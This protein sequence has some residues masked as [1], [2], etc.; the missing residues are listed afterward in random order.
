MKNPLF[1][2]RSSEILLIVLSFAWANFGDAQDVKKSLVI[3]I[4]GLGYGETGFSVAD[5]PVLDRLMNG[6]WHPDYNGAFTD[7]A[8]AGGVLGTPT[9][10]ITVSGPGWSTMTTGVWR[11]RHQVN[12]NGGNF[13]AGNF[14]DNPPYLATV[15]SQFPQLVTASFVNWGPIDS[16]IMGAVDSDADPTNNLNFRGDYA[17]D[18]LVAT[19]AQGALNP[20]SINADVTFVAFDQVDGAGHSCGSSGACYQNQ[21]EFTDGLVGQL[22]DEIVARPDFASE[23]W[24]IVVTSDHGHRPE[25]GHGGQSELE[26]RIPFIVV[27]QELKQ[28]ALPSVFQSVSQADVAPTVLD[29]FDIPLPDHYWGMSRA[30]GAVSINPD[31]NGDGIISGDGTGDFD[32]DDVTAFVSLWLQPNTADNPNPADLNLDGIA[33]LRDW[34]ILNSELP[35]MA[36]DVRNALMI[37]EPTGTTLVFLAVA[38]IFLRI[39]Q[40]SSTIT[41]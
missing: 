8:F 1:K 18:E 5:T 13:A 19:F 38:P 32:N 30:S 12:G 23:D 39:R 17:S 9:E 16:V 4:D 14:S 21:I 11:D 35:S 40:R 37:P 36:R 31:I 6:T 41:L 7:L 2:R 26:R 27:G 34:A 33:N 3:G 20:M 25:G 29:H 22:L 10:Q 15:K 28:G 24:Q